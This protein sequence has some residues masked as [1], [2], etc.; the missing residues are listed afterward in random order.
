MKKLTHF[1]GFTLL[2]LLIVVVILAILAG[3]ALPQYLRTVAR[4]RESEGWTNLASVR[5]AELRY[6]AEYSAYT[7]NVATLDITV[8]TVSPTRLF[9]YTT[10]IAGG[11][12]TFTG[13]ATPRTNCNLCRTLSVDNTGLRTTF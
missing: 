4:A 11:G 9:T 10:P 7:S 12:A 13:T 3:L 6:Y 1:K 8:D 2:E 5:S